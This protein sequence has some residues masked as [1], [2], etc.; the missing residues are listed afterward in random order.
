MS[1]PTE[2]TLLQMLCAAIVF[3]VFLLFALAYQY[4]RG[5]E[6]RERKYQAYQ[7]KQAENRDSLIDKKI[8]SISY[9]TDDAVIIKTEGGGSFTVIRYGKHVETV[10]EESK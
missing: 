2:P 6:E 7:K 8:E 1:K 10:A 4:S 9:D 3:M 5:S